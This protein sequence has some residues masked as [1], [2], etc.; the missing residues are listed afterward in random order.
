[1]LDYDRI[2]AILFDAALYGDSVAARRW[3]V[4]ARSVCRYRERMRNEP[5]L[6]DF[7]LRRTR[8]AEASIG[9]LRVRFLRKAL[10]EME[11]R[12]G[13]PDTTLEGIAECVRAVGE[14]H[15]VAEVMRDEGD[16][17]DPEAEQAEGDGRSVGEAAY[18]GSH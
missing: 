15:Q 17:G 7:V 9:A 14:Q 11:K 13:Q 18:V 4:S 12:L 1:M 8:D 10:I 5:E 3:N 2:A 16:G 6:A